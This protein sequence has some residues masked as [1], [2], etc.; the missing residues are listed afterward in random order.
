M[1]IG[2]T[3]QEQLAQRVVKVSILSDIPNTAGH[4]PEQVALVDPPLIRGFEQETPS[5]L[6]YSEIL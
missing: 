2:K 6:N 1:M 4:R 3:L 5:R